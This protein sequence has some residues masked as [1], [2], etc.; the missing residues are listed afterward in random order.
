[1]HL[2]GVPPAACGNRGCLDLRSR[3]LAVPFG[4]LGRTTWPRIVHRTDHRS[5]RL[6]KVRQSFLPRRG[7]CSSRTGRR[8]RWWRWPCWLTLEGGQGSHGVGPHPARITLPHVAWA[9]GLGPV[10]TPH[11]HGPCM[12]CCS[13]STVR[14]LAGHPSW[15]SLPFHRRKH[16]C[17]LLHLILPE[18]HLADAFIRGDAIRRRGGDFVHRSLGCLPGVTWLW[19]LALVLVPVVLVEA[20]LAFERFVACHAPEPVP[21]DHRLVARQQSRLPGPLL[22]FPFI[23]FFSLWALAA[24]L[25]APP[26]VVLALLRPPR[27]RLQPPLQ[28][29]PAGGAVTG[30]QER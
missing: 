23:P 10:C 13:S 16:C 27:S 3:A 24:R 1:M 21:L 19:G 22:L 9:V 4:K 12:V 29:S 6:Q 11:G 20:V 18:H 8:P 30:L 14:F 25:A 2:A 5:H 28:P 15:T 7:A 26:V 17:C